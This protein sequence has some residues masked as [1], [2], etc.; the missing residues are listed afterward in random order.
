MRLGAET[1]RFAIAF[2]A[3]LIYLIGRTFILSSLA[4][5]IAAVI[6]WTIWRL[7]FVSFYWWLFFDL[8]KSPER[9]ERLS[10]HPLLFACVLLVLATSPLV[11]QGWLFES[12]ADLIFILQIPVASAR[13][14]LFYRVILL[15]ALAKFNRPLGSV[16][17]STVL[18]TL[19]HVGVQ[20]M[21]L[22]TISAFAAS[23]VVFGLVYQLTRSFW[24]VFALHLAAD[25][26]VWVPHT[27]PINPAA[28]F[29]LNLAA[30]LGAML[31]WSAQ[32]TRRRMG[33][34]R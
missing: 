12:P 5:S 31:W 6:V 9:R 8:V 19:Y 10:V 33:I 16:I 7:V 34:D 27:S 3:E 29:F 20:P 26:L 32:E 28:G 23:G 2:G 17:L 4:D 21:S 18:F 15:N 30:L 13:E 22:A 1:R 11:H 25:L 24:V 14:E